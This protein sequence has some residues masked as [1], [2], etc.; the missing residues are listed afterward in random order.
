MEQTDFDLL[1]EKNGKKNLG[2]RTERLKFDKKDIENAFSKKWAIEN[3]KN[4]GLNFGHGILQD[5]FFSGHCFA[6][7]T[8]QDIPKCHLKITNRD[9]L[10]V[11][12]VIQWLGTNVGFCWLRETLKLA[13]YDIVKRKEG[14]VS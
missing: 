14:G 9:R 5:L 3:K 8:S 13:G 11:A 4:P 6:S 7:I 1:I 2:W 10:I 12:T